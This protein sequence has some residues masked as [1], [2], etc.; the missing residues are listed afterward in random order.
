VVVYIQ[1]NSKY[2]KVNEVQLCLW[3][4]RLLKQ[5]SRCASRSVNDVLE[6]LFMCHRCL[7]RQTDILSMS[8]VHPL[9]ADWVL[10]MVVSNEVDLIF[11]VALVGQ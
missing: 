2:F 4:A 9:L 10:L 11:E 6:C 1:G 3:G 5:I 7:I 8:A